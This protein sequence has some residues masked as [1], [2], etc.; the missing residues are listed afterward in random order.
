MLLDLE[1]HTDSYPYKV[2]KEVFQQI[3]G[4]IYRHIYHESVL[5]WANVLNVLC[6]WQE[7]IYEL[8]LSTTKIYLQKKQQREREKQ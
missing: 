3:Y 6:H 8:C 5:C 4:K 7:L 1:M 2:N